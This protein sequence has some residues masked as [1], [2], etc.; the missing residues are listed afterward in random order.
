MQILDPQ[1][2]HTELTVEQECDACGENLLVELADLKRTG[3]WLDANNI[4]FTCM[5]CEETQFLRYW[6]MNRV[7][8]LTLTVEAPPA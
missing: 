3:G 5:T 1:V 7:T 6:E 4:W 8:F 2:A